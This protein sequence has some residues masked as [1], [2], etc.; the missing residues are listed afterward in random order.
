MFCDNLRR[1]SL[2]NDDVSFPSGDIDDWSISDNELTSSE[3]DARILFGGQALSGNLV[4]ATISGTG[5]IIIGGTSAGN[6]LVINT[7]NGRVEKYASSS[8]VRW[9]TYSGDV[10]EITSF[11]D[12]GTAVI[13]D[14]VCIGSFPVG[15][16]NTPLFGIDG[17]GSVAVSEIRAYDVE[18]YDECNEDLPPC[19][20]PNQALPDQLKLTIASAT[21]SDAEY[22]GEYTLDK[23][24]SPSSDCNSLSSCCCYTVDFQNGVGTDL[25]AYVRVAVQSVYSAIFNPSNGSNV[26]LV[27][28]PLVDD[29]GTQDSSVALTDIDTGVYPNYAS[30]TFTVEVI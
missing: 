24:A 22:N 13:V 6:F 2:E 28:E 3:D 14:G 21:G 16:G 1:T 8:V 17:S 4:K 23:S 18:D 9:A 20:W 27:S 5:K 30:A 25:T 11:P 15:A 7:G 10:F 29:V 12:S 26:Y 19:Y